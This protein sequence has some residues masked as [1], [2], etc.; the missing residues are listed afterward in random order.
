M[1]VVDHVNQEPS[2]NRLANLQ[3]ITS[4]ENSTRRTGKG[5]SWHPAGYWQ[6]YVSN[7][8]KPRFVG[9]Y[10][11]EEEARAAYV[12]AKREA[13]KGLRVDI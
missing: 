13:T 7:N 9:W 2:D 4:H 5:Y 6:V 12:E 1:L 8:G 3:A 11:T 10:S